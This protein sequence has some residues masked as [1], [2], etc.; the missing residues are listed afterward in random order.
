VASVAGVGPGRGVG[1]SG[2]TGRR[3]GARVAERPQIGRFQFDAGPTA[4]ACYYYRVHFLIK[5]RISSHFAAFINYETVDCNGCWS[6]VLTGY[7]RV[8][9]GH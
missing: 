3:R 9:F 2:Q 8:D 1:A 6:L 4:G 5:A 7:Y